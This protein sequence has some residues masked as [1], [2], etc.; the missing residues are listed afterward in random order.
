MVTHAFNIKN[1]MSMLVQKS[2]DHKK[3][4]DHKMMIRYYAWLMISKKFKIHI[5][6]K[7]SRTSSNLKSKI[8]A[9]CSQA[10]RGAVE[11][12]RHKPCSFWLWGR[13]IMTTRDASFL[14]RVKPY[15]TYE[16]WL[17]DETK[18]LEVFCMNAFRQKKPKEGYKEVSWEAGLG[19]RTSWCSKSHGSSFKML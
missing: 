3:A 16:P 14:G 5:H 6:V 18:S 17:L 4:K 11:D 9:I 19:G 1:S 13:T 7:P 10:E 2:Q 15:A 12:I 8:T